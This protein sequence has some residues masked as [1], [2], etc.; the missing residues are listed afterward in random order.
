MF[1]RLSTPW[2]RRSPR[3]KHEWMG[4]RQRSRLVS[5]RSASAG[6]QSVATA[7]GIADSPP[8]RADSIC[9]SSKCAAFGQRF[10]EDP[11]QSY[12][13]Q[14]DEGRSEYLPHDSEASGPP[15]LWQAEAR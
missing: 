3:L 1:I 9:N 7:K 8:Y 11:E 13:Q 4:E 2:L 15:R 10:A 5:S 12:S 6:Q 14:N